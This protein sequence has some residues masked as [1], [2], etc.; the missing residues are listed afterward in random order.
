MVDAKERDDK[1]LGLCSDC[2][3]NK[4]CAQYGVIKCPEYI[5]ESK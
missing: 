5:G 3:H 4:E 2:Q 1:Y